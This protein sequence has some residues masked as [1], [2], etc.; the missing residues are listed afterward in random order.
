M[1]YETE[2]IYE[3]NHSDNLKPSWNHS[4]NI[5]CT[6]EL[7]TTPHKH[8]HTWVEDGTDDLDLD[9]EVSKGGWVV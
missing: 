5:D 9:F 2:Q 4:D 7:S 8:N 1:S 3:R 6:T